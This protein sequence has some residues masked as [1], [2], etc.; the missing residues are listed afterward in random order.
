MSSGIDDKPSALLRND[1]HGSSA[2][3]YEPAV[4]VIPSVLRSRFPTA[5]DAR[6]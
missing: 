3:A 1:P 2:I 6:V 5:L 4:H